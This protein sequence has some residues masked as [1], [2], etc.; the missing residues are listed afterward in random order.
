MK[1]T[2]T[3]ALCS[4]IQ[5]TFCVYGMVLLEEMNIFKDTRVTSESNVN[6]RIHGPW[7][8]IWVCYQKHC[9]KQM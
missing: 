1:T 5:T 9:W 8:L 2:Y 6:V 4:M 7:H 3:P